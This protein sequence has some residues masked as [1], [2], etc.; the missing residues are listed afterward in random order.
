MKGCTRRSLWYRL[1]PFLL[2]AACA[3]GAR[4]M[5]FLPIPDQALLAQS[6]VIVQGSVT[7]VAPA[8]GHEHSATLYTVQVEQV[9]KGAP[10]AEIGVLVPGA[11]DPTQPGA[12][13]IPGTPVLAEG[14]STLLFLDQRSG[15]DYVLVHLALGAFH[16][17]PG[18]AG[19]QVLERDLSQADAIDSA[20]S[21]PLATAPRYR[22]LEKFSAWLLQQAAG[23]PAEA[24]YWSATAPV[25]P[26]L[27]LPRYMLSSPPARWFQFDNG[28]AVTIYASTPGQTGLAGGGYPEFKQAMV[29]WDNN[30]AGKVYYVYGGTT[31]ATGDL[32][33]PDGVNKIL[34]NDPDEFLGGV[35]DCLNGGIAGYGGWVTAQTQELNGVTYEVIQQVDMTIRN[36]AGCLLSGNNNTNAVELFGHELGHTLGL[37]H[38]CGDPDEAACVAGSVQDQ[39]IMRPW[40]HADGRG[41]ALDSDDLAAMAY[42]YNL[43][44]A[45]VS[46]SSASGGSGSSSSSSSGGGGGACDPW[47][48]AALLLLARKRRSRTRH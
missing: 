8:P 15:G 29:A 18:A 37:L 33:N 19:G 21:E 47:T 14:E 48:L 4:A 32:D 46:P 5:S 34:F 3:T 2:L 39:A 7:A 40:I 25:G 44:P 27:V 20:T 43:P 41:A 30:G 42:L 10:A 1:V 35:F 38:P 13:T 16:V 9:L 28:Q 6:D 11:L 17:L 36:G 31:T 22:D 24:D 23:V 12:V 26:P 45:A